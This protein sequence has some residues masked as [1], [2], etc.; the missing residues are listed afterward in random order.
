MT[1]CFCVLQKLNPRFAR[2][3]LHSDGTHMHTHK[4][5][6]SAERFNS[7]RSFPEGIHANS[8]KQAQ[9]RSKGQQSAASV[10]YS[11]A[12]AALP[13]WPLHLQLWSAMATG[14]AAP[15]AVTCEAV[16]CACEGPG[17]TRGAAR[18]A[19]RKREFVGRAVSACECPGF[20]G[21]GTLFS[22][23]QLE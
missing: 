21:V 13:H 19:R 12:V 7:W 18:A 15:D 6:Q 22:V 1:S 5:T 23:F 8:T 11:A 3:T 20:L 17:A 4:H 14:K 16:L 9:I 10:R 2:P